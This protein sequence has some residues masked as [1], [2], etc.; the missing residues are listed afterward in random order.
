MDERIAKK[1]QI[2][3]WYQEELPDITFMPELPGSR[4]NRWLTTALFPSDPIAIYEALQKEGIESRPLWKP[5]HLQPLCEGIP[6]YG[7]GVSERLFAR[8]LCLPSGTQL[9][10]EEVAMIC[11]IIRKEL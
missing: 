8:G 4:G 2:F 6:F 3:R 1:R 7:T 9:G 11:E 5:M 10:R